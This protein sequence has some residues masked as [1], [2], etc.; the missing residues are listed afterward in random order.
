MCQFSGYFELRWIFK[1]LNFERGNCTAGYKW[2]PHH[3]QPIN[4]A[5]GPSTEGVL[6]QTL[7]TIIASDSSVSI[8]LAQNTDFECDRLHNHVNYNEFLHLHIKSITYYKFC[9]L[10]EHWLIQTVHWVCPFRSMKKKNY[11]HFWYN[12]ILRRR[13]IQRFLRKRSENK[14][15]DALAIIYHHSS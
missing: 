1:S 11:W 10:E 12:R 6:W 5:T 15:A 4:G 9:F 8:P 2:T 3:K 14:N 13:T 7:G